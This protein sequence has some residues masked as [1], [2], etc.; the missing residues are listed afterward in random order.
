MQNL[1][2]KL[3]VVLVFTTVFASVKAQIGIN[4][5]SPHATM[6]IVGTPDDSQKTDGLIAPR[7]TGDQLKAKDPLYSVLQDGVI[8]YVTTPLQA[9]T[10]TAKTINV[11]EK[12]YYSFDAARGANGEW[13]RMFHRYSQVFAGGSTGSANTGNAVVLSSASASNGTATLISRTF[14]LNRSGLVTF[15]FSIPIT[16]VTLADGTALSGGNSKLLAANMFITGGNLNNYLVVRSGISIA[17]AN[18]AAYTNSGYQVNGSRTILLAPGTYTVTL[19]P[20][21]F[22]QDAAGI[23]ATFGDNSYADTVL[24]IISLPA[25]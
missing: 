14:T 16:N 7:L 2:T 13:V 18:S 19:N 11:L 6:E 12:G 8:V 20:L 23:R 1:N 25:P 4:T 21:V 17:N 22:A 15:T 10:T 24:D 3:L 9:N 5:V